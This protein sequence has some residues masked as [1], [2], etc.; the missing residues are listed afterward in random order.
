MNTGR[1]ANKIAVVTGAGSGIGRATAALLAQ[2]QAIVAVADIDVIAARRVAS[3]IAE[4]G[5]KAEAVQL[6]VADEAEWRALI[7]QV[8]AAHRRLDILVNCAGISISKQV[9]QSTLDDWRKVL[10]VN[11]DGVFLGTKLAIDAMKHGGSIVNV[12]SVSG[13]TPSAGAAAYCASKAAVR[14]FSKTVAIECANANNGIRVNVVTPGGVK[15]P[16]WEKEEF[17]RSLV[18]EHG[19]TEEAFAAMADDTPSHRFFSPDEVA[20]TILYLA[21]DESAH[22]TGTEIVLDRGHTG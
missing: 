13:I 5:G 10:S 22:L 2:E 3:E 1:I 7:Q 8:T 16:M 19:G 6:D 12:A 9:A 17:F 20:E 11:L 18:A 14:I 15:T 21:S 4:S